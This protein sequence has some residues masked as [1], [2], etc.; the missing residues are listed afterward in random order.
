MLER[1]LISLN[2]PTIIIIIINREINGQSLEPEGMV[3]ST[4]VRDKD[5]TLVT[6]LGW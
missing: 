1:K 4:G 2:R 6:L 5:E 3:A